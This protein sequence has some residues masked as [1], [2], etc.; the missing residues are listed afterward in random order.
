MTALQEMRIDHVSTPAPPFPEEVGTEEGASGKQ[1]ILSTDTEHTALVGIS[2][3]TTRKSDELVRF[4]LGHL[5]EE[6]RGWFIDDLTRAVVQAWDTHS[7]LSLG[8]ALA[9]WEE[10]VALKLNPELSQMLDRAFDEADAA[11]EARGR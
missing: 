11:R 2:V 9:D 4:I 7:F 1:R 5:D 3:Y 6:E 10:T 8:R